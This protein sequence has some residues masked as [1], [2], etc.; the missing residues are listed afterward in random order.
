VSE[1]FWGQVR[2]LGN[3]VLGHSL[4]LFG[5]SLGDVQA[6]REDS[7]SELF[8][9]LGFVLLSINNFELVELLVWSSLE[10]VACCCK[11]NKNKSE[12]CNFH[13]FVFF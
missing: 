4:G 9:S 8:L 10:D 12:E 1:F 6:G 11:A 2:E 3:S 5:H 7:E 13:H